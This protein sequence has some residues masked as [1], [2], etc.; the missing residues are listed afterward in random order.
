MQLLDGKALA[1]LIKNEISLEVKQLV[2]NGGKQPHLA[3][4]LVGSDGASETYVG[5]KV[6]SCEQVGFLSTLLRFDENIS[7]ETLLNAVH[8]L[9]DNPNIDGFIVQLPLPKHISD[10]KII[11]A[12]NPNKDVDGFHPVNIGKLTLGLP[13]YVS[14]TPKGLLPY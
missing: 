6:K 5:H 14:A 9:N 4:I 8:D 10:E 7:E 3:A 13:T 2:N 11:N 12:I 1:E